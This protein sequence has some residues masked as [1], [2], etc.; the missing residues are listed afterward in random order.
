T[1]PASVSALEP[2]VG[3]GP[4]YCVGREPEIGTPRRAMSSGSAD[5]R[6]GPPRAE[7]DPPGP[8]STTP[9]GSSDHAM[10]ET[11]DGNPA[12]APEALTPGPRR[13][14][15]Y[16]IIST[17]GQGGM[18]SVFL[19]ED[20]SL[21]RRVALKRPRTDVALSPDALARFEREARAAAAL[22]HPSLCP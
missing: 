21:G 20:P 22:S 16:T 19:A 17:L 3:V 14:G 10:T 11:R 18:G 6:P 8:C 2:G 13:F 5:P 4:N 15:R 1:A 7:P 9:P 12:P